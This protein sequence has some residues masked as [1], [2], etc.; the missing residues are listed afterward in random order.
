MCATKTRTPSHAN[1]PFDPLAYDVVFSHIAHTKPLL[2][3]PRHTT[4]G[5]G[6]NQNSCPFTVRVRLSSC[7]YCTGNTVA[8]NGAGGK[9][10]TF[11]SSFVARCPIRWTTPAKMVGVEGVEPSPRGPRPRMHN[12]YTIPRYLVPTPGADPD[13]PVFQTGA[14]YRTCS[15]GESGGDGGSR[16]LNFGVQNRCVPA[17]TT[18]PNCFVAVPVSCH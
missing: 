1:P 7:V 11:V 17:S 6:S 14:M 4:P 8:R 12:R 10:L 13:S 3:Q 15:V 16:T 9:N 2:A 18:P 5:L